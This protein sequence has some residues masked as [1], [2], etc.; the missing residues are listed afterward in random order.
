MLELCCHYSI[1]E[2]EAYID[3][4]AEE[5]DAAAQP[6]NPPVYNPTILLPPHLQ[7]PH[8]NTP[9]IPLPAPIPIGGPISAG[10]P[11]PIPLPIPSS[12]DGTVTITT[13][14][15][16]SH[17]AAP[18][19]AA[20]PPPP[21]P[22]DPRTRHVPHVP[23]TQEGREDWFRMAGL[24]PNASQMMYPDD[25]PAYIRATDVVRG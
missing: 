19:A 16:H 1:S 17:A 15:P 13:N 24:V 22:Q 25:T 5:R 11:V 12:A 23:V 14:G 21:P 10:I 18:P 9:A 8:V 2:I 3:M 20:A 7:P 4:Y 6:H